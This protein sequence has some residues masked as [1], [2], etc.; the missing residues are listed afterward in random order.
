M[1]ELDET[2]DHY[3]RVLK[4]SEDLLVELGDAFGS[5]IKSFYRDDKGGYD[6]AKWR[7]WLDRKSGIVPSDLG[8][9]AREDVIRRISGNEKYLNS[10]Y[11]FR[12]D[13]WREWLDYNLRERILV[14]AKD[15]RKY[16]ARWQALHRPEAAIKTEHLL[17]TLLHLSAFWS[18][19]LYKL[20]KLE[21]SAEDRVPK[22]GEFVKDPGAVR[23]G[24]FFQLRDQIR[25]ELGIEAS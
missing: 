25:R 3:R 16:Q 20:N 5:T 13:A 12:V 7:A 17:G 2:R 23:W 15:H 10:D 6:R 4:E 24:N 18:T 9:P 1:L 11:T 19:E 21:P 8:G 14:L 22:G